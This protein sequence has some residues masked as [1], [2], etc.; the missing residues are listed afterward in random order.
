LLDLL[1]PHL[2]QAFHTSQLFTRVSEIVEATGQAWLVVDSTGHILFESGKAVSWLIEYFG[3]SRSLPSQIQ[4]WL[5]RR[6]TRFEDPSDL[7]SPLKEFSVRRGLKLLVVRSLS[8]VQ[9][10][11]QRLLLS[12]TKDELDPR[13]P[14]SLGLTKREAEVSL[15]IS[16]GK[17]NCEIAGIL[18]SA[19][20]TTDDLRGAGQADNRVR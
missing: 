8:P 7:A 20:R 16:Q 13:P 19:S 12:E 9:S 1:V 17:R 3:Q 14:R 2:L 4:D 11:E 15:W 18:G 5:K 10:P 6:A